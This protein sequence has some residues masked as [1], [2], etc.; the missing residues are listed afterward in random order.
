MDNEISKIYEDV[1]KFKKITGISINDY[2][3]L[4]LAGVI[5]IDRELTTFVEI[6]GVDL[7]LQLYNANNIES[8]KEF[9]QEVYNNT[10]K[11][12][13]IRI[14]NIIY[15]FMYKIKNSK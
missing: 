2:M 1:A 12:I 15:D 8:L 9:K 10:Y 13:A 4:Y 6:H 3:K 7:Y 5:D 11:G 14:R